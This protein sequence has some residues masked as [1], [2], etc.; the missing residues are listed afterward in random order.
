MD[1]KK[2]GNTGLDVS[3][4]GFGCG[5]VGGLMVR[6]DAADQ[7]RAVARALDMGITYFD[8]AAAYG[9][10][11]SE[12]N[13]G[14]V[15]R[16][17]KPRLIVGTKFTAPRD[18][19][20]MQAGIAA[21]LDAS[22]ARLG[23]ETVD[24]FQMHN[25][26]SEGG[27][28]IHPQ[29]VLDHVLPALDRL[30]AQGK[31]RFAGFTAIGDTP[32]IR[33]VME[34]PGIACAQVPFNLLN[35]SAGRAVPAAFP[36]QD[37]GNLIGTAQHGGKGVIAIRVL[38]AGALSGSVARHP[39][40][41]PSVDP[42]G[43]GADYVADVR[44]TAALLDVAREAGVD[45]TVALAIRFAISQ[46]GISTAMVGLSNLDQLEFAGAAAEQGPLPPAILA[47]IADIQ[48]SFAGQVR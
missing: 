42:I 24:L 33:Q 22:L 44:R 31:F 41:V 38:A 28:G 48:D 2:L 7:E 9:N 37:Y 16:A 20:T 17:L 46:P 3:A 35:P 13:L 34:A 4:I 10:G 19:A 6:G 18:P 40:G 43:S 26:V 45:G 29:M 14:R 21:S 39:I 12:T 15:L 23:V 25:P 8:T 5:A 47:R 11:V 1:I 36:G 30:R 27:E 32:A